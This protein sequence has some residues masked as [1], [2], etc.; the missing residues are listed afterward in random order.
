M[1][2]R[3]RR[4]AKCASTGNKRCIGQLFGSNPF[5]RDSIL[6]VVNPNAADTSKDTGRY[7]S[8]NEFAS[9]VKVH[10]KRSSDNVADESIL[11]AIP[12]HNQLQLNALGVQPNRLNLFSRK[13]LSS[14]NENLLHGNIAFSSE[15]QSSESSKADESS[16]SQAGSNAIYHHHHHG[17]FPIQPMVQPADQPQYDVPQYRPEDYLPSYEYF[18][19]NSPSFNPPQSHPTQPSR[20][21]ESQPN[22]PNYVFG[23]NSYKSTTLYDVDLQAKDSLLPLSSSAAPTLSAVSSSSPSPSPS[24][25][26]SGCRC[27]PE[28]FNDLLHH[29]QSSYKQ[30]HNGM[31]QLFETFKSQSNCASNSPP[32]IYGD[33]DSSSSHSHPN[34]DYKTLCADRNA[35][36]SDLELATRCID[37]FPDS[38]I[39]PSSGFYEP[40][41]QQIKTGGF[42]NQ[43]MSY[44]DY[45]KM[46]RNVNAN[47][48]TVLSSA[49]D[50]DDRI[51]ASAHSVAQ[52]DTQ[53]QTSNQLR[54]HLDKIKDEQVAAPAPTEEAAPTT[55]SKSLFKFDVKSLFENL[56]RKN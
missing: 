54:Q 44:A 19:K 12:I 21:D 47:T 35:V 14:K 20:T 27:D 13:N 24:T 8:Q 17:S 1:F 53:D 23:P 32:M 43:F 10:S 34:F 50:M 48:G 38:H 51:V 42:E 18:P 41:G 37:A 40:P 26:T 39:N 30:F 22:H 31:I 49:Y 52:D 7:E 33:G 15:K 45:I 55:A 28:Q 29:M 3:Q 5:F 4:S 9:L 11:Q 6:G 25:S 46:M 36:N 16:S 56:G 2:S